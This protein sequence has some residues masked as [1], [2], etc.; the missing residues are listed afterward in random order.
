M[1]VKAYLKARREANKLIP[2]DVQLKIIKSR[3]A[4]VQSKEEE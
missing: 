1:D 2:K 3:L 4:A